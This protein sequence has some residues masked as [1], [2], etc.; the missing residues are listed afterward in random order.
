MNLETWAFEV[1]R[2]GCIA[3]AEFS[4]ELPRVGA[5]LKHYSP[6]RLKFLLTDLTM[7]GVPFQKVLAN[8][9]RVVELMAEAVAI[10]RA[11]K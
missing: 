8:L 6:T 11:K 3:E 2:D 1:I 5:L 10:G 7:R 4:A 9:E